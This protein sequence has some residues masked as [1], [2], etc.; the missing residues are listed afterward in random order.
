MAEVDG[1]HKSHDMGLHNEQLTGRT[2]QI[3]FSAEE[4]DSYLYP[5]SF[6]VDLDNKTEFDAGEMEI[7]AINLKIR[8]VEEAMGGMD[9]VDRLAK[10]ED[11]GAQTVREHV[12]KV[13][14]AG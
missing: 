9:V 1:Q 5:E 13:L 8:D 7:S 6:E 10:L 14:N 11:G 4:G 3:F 12:E 2:Q